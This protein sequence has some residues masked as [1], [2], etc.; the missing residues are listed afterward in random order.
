MS[1][2]QDI[3]E[4]QLTESHVCLINV[5][6]CRPFKW[7]EHAKVVINIK[8]NKVMV[9]DVVQTSVIPDSDY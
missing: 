7:M 4:H 2:A 6:S 1:N 9:L 5:E 8:D 3:K